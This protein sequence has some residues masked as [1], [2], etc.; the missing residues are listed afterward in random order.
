LVLLTLL[1]D[2]T[3]ISIAYDNVIPSK[4]PEAWRLWVITGISIA[5]GAVA[6]IG[7][8]GQYF[9]YTIPNSHSNNFFGYKFHDSCYY[10]QGPFPGLNETQKAAIA[11][12][13]T[14]KHPI[15]NP[16]C[17]GYD[18]TTHDCGEY[19][20]WSETIT[21]VYLCLS[22][23][24][25]M[26]VFVSRTKHSFWS[27]RPGY[28]MLIACFAAQVVA[29]VFCAYWPLSLKINAYISVPNTTGGVTPLQVTM[30]FID[31]KMCGFIWVY[32]LIVF[33]IQDFVKVYC[34][35]SFDNDA[36]PEVDLQEI[37][38]KRKPFLPVLNIFKKKKGKGKKDKEDKEDKEKDKK[39]KEVRKSSSK[40]EY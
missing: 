31:W 11:M 24:G 30:K 27:R 8:F 38:K 33:V 5:V 32:S 15:C 36:N 1:N 18:Q 26:T 17:N 4:K 37:K 7:L 21:V 23:G 40:K 34:F 9:L 16:N 25:Q 28:V 20:G 22:I 10:S 29:T 2:G 39:K 14:H 12:L 3:V 13:D 35:Y 6:T 19:V